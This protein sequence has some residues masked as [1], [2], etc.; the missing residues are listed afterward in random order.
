MAGRT[1]LG[2]SFRGGTDRSRARACWQCA[3]P[4]RVRERFS[5]RGLCEECSAL[6]ML[7]WHFGQGERKRLAVT[8][9]PYGTYYVEYQHD[10]AA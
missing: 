9:I 7:A 3:T 1:A 4:R 8:E 6:N 10:R 5:Y 2:R